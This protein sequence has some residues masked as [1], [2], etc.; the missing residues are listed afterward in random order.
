MA[1][2]PPL[3]SIIAEH[4][5]NADGTLD[6]QRLLFVLNQ[7]MGAVYSALNR[8]I[9]LGANILAEV[10]ELPLFTTAATVEATFPM[11]LTM[12]AGMPPNPK[13]V[14]VAYA[15]NRTNTSTLFYSPPT[16]DWEPVGDGRIRIKYLSGLDAST[17]YQVGLFVWGK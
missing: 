5:T 3:Q 1:A 12:S 11:Y 9:A 13:G 8:G 2:L 10:K 6:P 14:W 16:V 7:F 17:K 15:K 4:V